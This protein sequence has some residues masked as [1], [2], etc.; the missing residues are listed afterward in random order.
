MGVLEYIPGTLRTLRLL[1]AEPEEFAAQFG[2][3]LHEVAQGVAQTSYDFLKGFRYETRPKFLG[4]LVVERETGQLCGTC[5]FKGPP[6]ESGAVDIAYFTFPGCEGRGIATEMARFLVERAREMENV[7][8]VIAHTVPETS[9]ST[10]VLE[11]TG[12]RFAGEAEEDGE[13]V[14]RWEM[15]LR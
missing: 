14:W 8:R 7:E 6:D 2:V 12:M 1:A 9:A 4:Y 3:R 13:R 5:S 15:A 10:R 11:K